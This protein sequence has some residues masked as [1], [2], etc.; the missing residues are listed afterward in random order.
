MQ[1]KCNH[2]L[3]YLQFGVLASVPGLWHGVF[4]RYALD[5]S[6]RRRSFNLGLNGT[7]P[8]P[9]VWRNRQQMLTA[10]GGRQAVFARQV[11]GADVALWERPERLER[12]PAE[13]HYLSGDALV[14][15]VPGAALVIQTADCQ[16]VV[17]ADPMRRVVANV[18]SGWRGSIQNVVGQTV[19]VM[20]ARYGCRAED[21]VGGI[22]PSLGPC[23]AEFVNYHQ[24][25]PG[26][27][28]SYRRP[29]DLFDFWR[30]SV[31]QLA[32][33]GVPRERIEVSGICTRC[34][35]HLF[36][37]YRGEGKAAGRFAAM[38]VLDG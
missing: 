35:P 38:V 13:G 32:A 31:D 15:D 6:G 36:Y 12:S 23:C 25:I 2:T 18:H 5:E 24:E 7:A 11:H 16:S 1:W 19:G 21:I 9:Q 28:W 37:S 10:G 22:G 4:P 29:G 17:L 30:L 14:T 3:H 34:N 33:A 8:E 26:R 20:V 27:Y